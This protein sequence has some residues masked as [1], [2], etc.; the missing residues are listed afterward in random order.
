MKK[1]QKKAALAL[2]FENL[3]ADIESLLHSTGDATVDEMRVVKDKLHA[4]VE[5]ARESV[6]DMSAEL[7]KRAGKSAKKLN[8]EVHEEPWKAVG[9]GA[10]IGLL[11]GMLFARR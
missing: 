4:R 1:S 10:A 7:A 11:L 2:E 8:T 3:L 5:E 6:V 9:A